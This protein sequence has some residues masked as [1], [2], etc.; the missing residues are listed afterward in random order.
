MIRLQRKT[1]TP[2]CTCSA[3]LRWDDEAL[4]DPHVLVTFTPCEQHPDRTGVAG[5]MACEAEGAVLS[6]VVNYLTHALPAAAVAA[7]PPEDLVGVRPKI[8]QLLNT[9]QRSFPLS[10]LFTPYRGGIIPAFGLENVTVLTQRSQG[11]IQRIIVAAR[12][13]VEP[14]I[15]GELTLKL[16]AVPA[17]IVDFAYQIRPDGL[18]KGRGRVRYP[19]EDGSGFVDD[20]VGGAVEEWDYTG[21]ERLASGQNRRR[22]ATLR[23]GS[24]L[25]IG[26][27]I[28]L[29]IVDPGPAV[30]MLLGYLSQQAGYDITFSYERTGDLSLVTAVEQLPAQEFPWLDLNIGFGTIRQLVTAQLADPVLDADGWTTWD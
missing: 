8:R 7:A 15:F 22:E 10:A 12:E 25:G 19:L 20:F 29:N 30:G 24:L 13:D 9:S 4:T 3:I 2:T 18:H 17:V 1:Y 23:A 5:Y 26:L 16:D 28:G 21:T 11:L 27:K 14:D 6:E